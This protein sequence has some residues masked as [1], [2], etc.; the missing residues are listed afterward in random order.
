MGFTKHSPLYV[1]N[2][3]NKTSDFHPVEQRW[4]HFF[5]AIFLQFLKYQAGNIEGCRKILLSMFIHRIV[6]F[7]LINLK[8]KKISQKCEKLTKLI[9]RH[10]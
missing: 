8:F 10:T 9:L 7:I 6:I 5:H 1:N 2:N 4:I 3:K